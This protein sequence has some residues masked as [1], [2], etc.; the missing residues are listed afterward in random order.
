MGMS[1]SL[2]GTD[3]PNS[4][5]GSKPR[6]CASFA[7]RYD[8]RVCLLERLDPSLG[9]WDE[10]IPLVYGLV[11][12][13]GTSL[14]KSVIFFCAS[15]SIISIGFYLNEF[16]AIIW[17]FWCVL[18]YS[19]LPEFSKASGGESLALV[20]LLLLWYSF[21][22]FDCFFLLMCLYFICSA[23]CMFVIW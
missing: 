20:W 9:F 11:G 1:Y 10:P 16:G 17:A 18:T 12:S 22:K 19:M 4:E 15:L 23:I 14:S 6:S 7:G 13:A 3:G 2:R 21:W 8:W 5:G